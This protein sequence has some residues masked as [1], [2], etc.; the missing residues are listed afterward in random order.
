[1]RLGTKA[2]AY[3]AAGLVLAGAILFSG[4]TFGLLNSSSTGFLSVLLTDPPNVPQGVTAVYITYANLAVHAVGFGDSGW[5]RVSG[6][7]TIDTMKLVNLS[8]VIST[9]S[10][11]SL[12]YN[13]VSFNITKASV[14]FN[15][16]NY[17]ASISSGKL[18][19]PIVG[20][21][22]INSSIPAAALVDIQPNVLNLGNQT[23]PHFAIATGARAL[24]VPSHDVVADQTVKVVG[25]NHSLEGRSWYQSFRENHTGEGLA[26]SGLAFTSN[27]LTFTAANKGSDPVAIRLVILT[28]VQSNL[29]S[30]NS[31]G[32]GNGSN[33][34]SVIFVV[35]SDGSLKLANG[36]PGQV[37]S[38]FEGESGGY[39][40]SGG[41]SHTFSFLGTIMNLLGKSGVMSG[42]TYNVVIVGPQDLGN[43]T[44]VAG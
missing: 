21:L 13:L 22:K 9:G 42:T 30:D 7:G 29:N 36:T 27:S 37:G 43:I 16:K 19:V 32:M 26:L 12:T 33:A 8:R 39:S 38:L 28:P 11:P 6:Q 17:S 31:D 44:V 40:L 41:S 18:V 14:D 20:G 15:G 4:S 5:V 25:S 2:A 1:L 3:G 23:D 10:I 34:N 35:Q 24:Q